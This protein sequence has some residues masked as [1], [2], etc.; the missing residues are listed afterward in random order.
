[1]FA[2]LD[3]FKLHRQVPP[4]SCSCLP[5]IPLKEVPFPTSL[6]K[7]V[8]MS[9][10]FAVLLAISIGHL[11]GGVFSSLSFIGCVQLYS[12]PRKVIHDWMVKGPESQF[13]HPPQKRERSLWSCSIPLILETWIKM[14]VKILEKFQVIN[15]QQPLEFSRSSFL[16]TTKI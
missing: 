2:W 16:P 5:D 3:A 6:I 13:Y 15:K 14:L 1:M 7:N 9:Y 4:C 11:T 10:L 12:G 8:A